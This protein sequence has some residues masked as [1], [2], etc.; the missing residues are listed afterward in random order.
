MRLFYLKKHVLYFL[1]LLSLFFVSAQTE[2]CGDGILQ[3]GE[4]CDEDVFFDGINDCNDVYAESTPTEEWI[5]DLG[6][7]SS[8]QGD[9]ISIFACQLDVGQCELE[10]PNI[11]GESECGDC[12]QFD[13][14]CDDLGDDC[15]PV[16]LCTIGCGGE[17]SCYYEEDV[18]GG[19]CDSC[20]DSDSPASCED[21]TDIGSCVRD[22]CKAVIDNGYTCEWISASGRCVENQDCQW[23]C[24]QIYSDECTNGFKEK[25]GTECILLSGESTECDNNNPGY[26]FPDQLGCGYELKNFPVFTSWNIVMTLILLVGYYFVRRKR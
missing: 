1:V 17:G 13:D 6:C 8:D 7:Y 3:P 26:T 20:I 10:D 15:D 5:G 11:P 2:D 16:A 25:I 22:D 21:Y 14:I 4:Y 19:S 12:S 18:L 9:G 24:S 23:D